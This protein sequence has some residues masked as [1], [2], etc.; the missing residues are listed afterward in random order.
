[1]RERRMSM[2]GIAGILLL[3]AVG[4][5]ATPARA[6][7][8]FGGFRCGSRLVRD[9]DTQDDVAKKCG[10]PDAVRTWTEYRTESIWEAGRK[11]ERSI[12]ITYDEW[13][14]DL[15]AGRLIRYAVFVQGRLVSTRTGTYGS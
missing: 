1:M 11:L 9:G 15:G 4:A 6:E 3:G 10:D 13:K 5:A 8:G 14:Y 12:P 7:G 2:W